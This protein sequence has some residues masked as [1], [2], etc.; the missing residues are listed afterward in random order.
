MGDIP[1]GDRKLA[2]LFYIWTKPD[3]LHTF[4]FR[5]GYIY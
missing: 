5:K 1:A 3:V 2:K 4:G